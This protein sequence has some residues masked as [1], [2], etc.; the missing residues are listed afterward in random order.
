MKK[1]LAVILSIILA[2]GNAAPVSAAKLK[3]N[4]VE[5]IEAREEQAAM[6][7]VSGPAEGEAGEA[8]GQ[9]A[10]EEQPAAAGEKPSEVTGKNAPGEAVR[11]AEAPA[12]DE[13]EQDEAPSG[14]DK[15]TEA[16]QET[17]APAETGQETEAQAAERGEKGTYLGT[18]TTTGYSNPDGSA[19]ADGTMPRAQHTVSADWK[20]LPP[21]TRIRF[22]DSD[23]IYTVEDTGV[24]GN[25]V[26]VYY[27]THSEAWSHGLK[28]KEV[29]LVD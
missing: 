21:G 22:G 27:P 6:D 25:W 28:Y 26:D 9:Q 16:V 29:Y 15:E 1:H 24:H 12:G 3:K 7:A 19:S 8:E 10:G 18:F 5:N 23:I 4:H 11:Q 14:A 13:Q 2:L 17:E 20:V